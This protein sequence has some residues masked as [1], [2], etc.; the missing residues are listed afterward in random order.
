M[1]VC[2][3]AST[4]EE[5]TGGVDASGHVVDEEDPHQSTSE[6]TGVASTSNGN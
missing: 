6:Q 4:P 2:F 5:V 3:K 1:V